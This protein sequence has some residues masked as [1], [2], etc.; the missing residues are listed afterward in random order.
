MDFL[1][2]DPN[3]RVYN[4]AWTQDEFL[5]VLTR[6]SEFAPPEAMRKFWAD[7]ARPGVAIPSRWLQYVNVRTGVMQLFEVTTAVL[8]DPNWTLSVDEVIAAVDARKSV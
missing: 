5:V 4:T 3:T 6:D 8:F 7:A 2:V 1:K